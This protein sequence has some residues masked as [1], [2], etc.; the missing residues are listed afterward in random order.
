MLFRKLLFLWHRLWLYFFLGI[1]KKDFIYSFMREAETQ[2]EAGE[3]GSMQG[4]RCGTPS[5]EPGITPWAKGRCSIAEPLRHPILRHFYNGFCYCEFVNAVFSPPSSFLCWHIKN[6]SRFMFILTSDLLFYSIF[7]CF[8]CIF[9][10]I[11]HIST[12]NF[13]F[14][15]LFYEFLPYLFSSLI[16]SNSRTK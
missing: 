13:G 7:S 16:A 9:L 15:S 5:R 8:P 2:A 3:A 14:I 6:L 1:F 12:N 10:V 11:N 4:A